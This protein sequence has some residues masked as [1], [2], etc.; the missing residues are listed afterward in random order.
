M[1]FALPSIYQTLL[2]TTGGT[3]SDA[4]IQIDF[5]IGE[6]V[7]TDVSRN[8]TSYNIRFRQ[9]YYD[10]FSSASKSSKG[11]VQLFSNPFSESFRIEADTEI[12]QYFLFDAKSREVSH[13]MT[14]GRTFAYDGS[15]LPLRIYQLRVVLKS[16]EISTSLLVHQ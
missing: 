11:G 7:V 3:I 8:G 14:E 1:A 5:S 4:Q 6:S 10:V 12:D 15:D 2:G 16:E 9:P 13:K